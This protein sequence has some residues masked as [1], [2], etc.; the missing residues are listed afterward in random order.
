MR[1]L[2]FHGY[3]GDEDEVVEAIVTL[4]TAYP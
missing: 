3:A 1:A 4:M 2:A